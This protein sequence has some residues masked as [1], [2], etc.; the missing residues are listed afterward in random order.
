MTVLGWRCA[1]PPTTLPPPPSGDRAGSVHS[2][3]DDPYTRSV[4]A[5]VA[6]KWLYVCPKHCCG[7]FTVVRRFSHIVVL[8]VKWRILWPAGRRT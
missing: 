7:H 1:W 5:G 4:E 6:G 2:L 3:M 8:L